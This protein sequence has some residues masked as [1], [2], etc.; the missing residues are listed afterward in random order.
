MLSPAARRGLRAPSSA[1][2]PAL[3]A[4]AALA[5]L[6]LL[7]AASAVLLVRAAPAD[8]LDGLTAPAALAQRTT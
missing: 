6:F 2:R 1:A 8:I 3:L 7:L 5:A 4:I